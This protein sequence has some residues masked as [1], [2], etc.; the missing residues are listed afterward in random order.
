MNLREIQVSPARSHL[1]YWFR[2]T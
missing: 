2:L 1:V